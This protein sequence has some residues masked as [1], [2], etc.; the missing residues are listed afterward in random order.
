[1]KRMRSRIKKIC[2]IPGINV[3]DMML[4]M[5]ARG[6]AGLDEWKRKYSLFG[7]RGE[8]EKKRSPAQEHFCQIPE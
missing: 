4:G 2:G 5:R 1:L 8:T 3:V 6:F 7:G